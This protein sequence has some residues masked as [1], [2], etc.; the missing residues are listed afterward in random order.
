MA[1]TPG[2][3]LNSNWGYK[4][5][6]GRTACSDA[7]AGRAAFEGLETK[8]MAYYLINGTLTDTPPRDHKVRAFVDL[9]SYGQLCKWTPWG[10]ADISHVPLR[11]LVRRLPRRR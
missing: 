3:D 1:L 9:H 11:V 5:K 4:F 6:A 2:L 10:A 7:Y 8:A